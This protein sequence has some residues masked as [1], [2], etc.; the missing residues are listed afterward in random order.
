MKSAV[1]DCSAVV[2]LLATDGLRAFEESEELAEC[3][4]VAP[5]LIDPEFVSAMRRHTRRQP[6][7]AQQ[8]ELAIQAFYRLEIVRME[9]EPLWQEA[10]RWRENLTAYDSMYVALARLLDVPLLTADERLA[11]AAQPWCEVRRV[12][13]LAAA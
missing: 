4:F 11:S 12:S 13:D 2:A 3:I 10:W 6:E 7:K 9:H 5:H 1:L 8:S